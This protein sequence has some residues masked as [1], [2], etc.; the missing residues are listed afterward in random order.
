[1]PLVRLVNFGKIFFAQIPFETL[2]AE[3]LRAGV[4]QVDLA[5]LTTPPTEFVAALL[6][7]GPTAPPIGAP[8]CLAHDYTKFR[9]ALHCAGNLANLI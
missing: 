5:A 3:S 7:S 2:M 1:M 6:V 8:A 9:V 4:T